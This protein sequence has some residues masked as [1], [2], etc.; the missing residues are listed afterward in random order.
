MNGG[1]LISSYCCGAIPPNHHLDIVN[2][3]YINDLSTGAGF[4]YLIISLFISERT[5]FG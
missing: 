4:V 3:D 2:P 5:P 1:Y